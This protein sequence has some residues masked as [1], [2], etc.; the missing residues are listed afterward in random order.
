MLKLKEIQIK[1]FK[2]LR[3][4]KLELGKF[5]VLIGANATGKTNLVD[6]F[7]L[8]R[9]IY[10]EKDINPFRYWWGYQNA[11]WNRK[12]EFDI[13]VRFCF[14]YFNNKSFNNKDKIYDVEFETIFTG[15]DGGFEIL[16]EKL[17]I[18]GFNEFRID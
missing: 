18:K 5:N 9:K 16:R 4:C 6:L 12:K 17:E 15:R 2:S 11:V 13:S 14:E 10:V 1:N 8:L 7:M 3:D